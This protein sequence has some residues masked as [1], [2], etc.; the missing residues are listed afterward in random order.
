[1][2]VDF[3]SPIP[4]SYVQGGLRQREVPSKMWLCSSSV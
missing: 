2:N 3:S 1:L 4:D